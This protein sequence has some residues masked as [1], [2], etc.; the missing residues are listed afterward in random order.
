MLIFFDTE[1]TELHPEAKLISVG[2]VAED[3]R[4]F[5]AELS[6][7]WRLDD[8]SEFVRTEVLPYLEG[9]Q[10][11]MTRAELCLAL[12]NWL[13]SFER[14]VQLVTDAPSWDWPWIAVIFDEDHLLP[15]NLVRRPALLEQTEQE[16]EQIR[17][18]Q[19]SRRH[20]ALDDARVMRLAWQA[21]HKVG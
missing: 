13:E 2:L 12:G 11:L 8:C 17:Q 7:T 9:G 15:A 4:D 6:D 19:P 16:L 10:H 5:Y 18:A 3:G 20:H 21:S 14:S 1:F